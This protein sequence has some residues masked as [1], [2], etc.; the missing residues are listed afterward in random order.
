MNTFIKVFFFSMLVLLLN[1]CGGGGGGSPAAMCIV[2]DIPGQ[3]D[4]LGQPRLTASR[5]SP[6]DSVSV[7]IP[8]DVDTGYVYALLIDPTHTIS[9]SVNGMQ[10]NHPAAQT[11]TLD[12]PIGDTVS[13]SDMIL[14]LTVCTDKASCPIGSGIVLAPTGPGYAISYVPAAP[15][16][17]N[18]TRHISYAG[19]ASTTPTDQATCLDVATVNVAPGNTPALSGTLDTAYNHSGVVQLDLGGDEYAAASVVQPDG[20][21]VVLGDDGVDVLLVRLNLDGS[22]DHGFAGN[23]IARIDV[24]GGND[25]ASDLAIDPYGRLLVTGRGVIGGLPQ[26][27]VLRVMPDGTLDS[28]FGL[29]GVTV[30]PLS[31]LFTNPYAIALDHNGRIVVA[32]SVYN[33]THETDLFLTRFLPDGAADPTFNGSGYAIRDVN[34]PSDNVSNEHIYDIAID[35]NNGI[36]FVGA[37]NIDYTSLSTADSIAGHFFE[38][39][40]PDLRF[41]IASTVACI[42]TYCGIGT[43]SPGGSVDAAFGMVLDNNGRIL[44][45]GKY[46]DSL[47]L[48]RQTANGLYDSTITYIN[49]FTA[50]GVDLGAGILNLPDGRILVGGSTQSLWAGNDVFR[51]PSFY[52][53]DFLLMQMTETGLADTAFGDTGTGSLVSDVTGSPEQ[54]I[55][56]SRR[57][58]DNGVFA[59]GNTDNGSNSDILITRY[60]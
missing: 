20:K 47:L 46:G 26:T 12:F 51:S 38:D 23:G 17:A 41:G 52:S 35:S 2:N 18:L 55:S 11:V 50:S 9:P 57:G 34:I 19:T 30:S 31:T 53:G 37:A 56:L 6:G 54:L 33:S 49:F 43:T 16:D 48:S 13:A 25:R 44:F 21:L 27:F 8:V 32:G 28:S 15:G 5:V 36:Y 22:L 4:I 39:G 24:G 58:G 10:I 14:S 1:A 40:S 3:P 45:T 29:S 7:G 60:R 59:V 42:T